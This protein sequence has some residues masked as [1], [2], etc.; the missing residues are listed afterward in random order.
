MPP[1]EVGYEI[2]DASGAVTSQLEIA[3]P[4][5]QLGVAIAEADLNAASKAGW[6]VWTMIDALELC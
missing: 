3:W 1:P 4:R 6:K 2:H 5:Q